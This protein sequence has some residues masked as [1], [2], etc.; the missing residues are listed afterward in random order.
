MSGSL[1]ATIKLLRCISIGKRKM[2]KFKDKGE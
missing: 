2:Y 1:V